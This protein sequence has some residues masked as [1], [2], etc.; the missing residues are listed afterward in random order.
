MVQTGS[1]G[2]CATCPKA[3]RY[4]QH[5]AP[6]RGGERR[7]LKWFFS[8]SGAT[9]PTRRGGPRSILADVFPSVPPDPG[10]AGQTHGVVA[11]RRGSI[12]STFRA[13]QRTV[14]VRKSRKSKSEIHFPWHNSF[15]APN[16]S[17]TF[18]GGVLIDW[19]PCHLYRK[20]FDGDEKAMEHFLAT[21]CTPPGT[22]S[23][24]RDERLPTPAPP[25]EYLVDSL[26]HSDP[27]RSS[28]TLGSPLTHL[29]TRPSGMYTSMNTIPS[30]DHWAEPAERSTT[31]RY[32]G[33]LA[34]KELM[35]VPDRYYVDYAHEWLVKLYEAWDKPEKAA[36]WKKK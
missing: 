30:W 5:E 19:N 15:R 7:S 18:V 20:L 6:L 22:L 32:R 25:S 8:T 23:K 13:G 17:P 2:N 33:I 28:K 34:R 26:R 12:P 1:A 16:H 35:G 27:F 14:G 31:R 9:S 36:E 3:K 21:V 24:M 4:P 10:C 29:D 11:E